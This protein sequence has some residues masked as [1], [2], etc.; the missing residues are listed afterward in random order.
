MMIL[1]ADDDPVHTTLLS[2]RLTSKGHRVTVVHDAIQ[3]WLAAIRRPPDAIILDIQ[4]PGGTGR[5]VLRQLKTNPNTKQVP[6]IVV[7]GSINPEDEITVMELGASEFLRK[8]VDLNHLF[9]SLEKLLT[10]SP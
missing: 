5:A 2:A 7:S 9:S 8:P 10:V 1:I 3:A 4:M 6:V